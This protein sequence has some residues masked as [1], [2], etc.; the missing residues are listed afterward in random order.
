MTA[1]NGWLGMLTRVAWGAGVDERDAGRKVGVDVPKLKPPRRS[2]AVAPACTWEPVMTLDDPSA[3]Y[4]Y[5][6]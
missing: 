2:V 3:S 1:S 5:L 6:Q 4:R